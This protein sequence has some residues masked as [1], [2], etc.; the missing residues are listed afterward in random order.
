MEKIKIPEEQIAE[1]EKLDKE[2]NQRER[3]ILEKWRANNPNI[4]RGICNTPE[5]KALRQ[6]YKEKY[7]AILEKYKNIN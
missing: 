4:K 5:M 1:F 6:E 3:A 2:T 7:F